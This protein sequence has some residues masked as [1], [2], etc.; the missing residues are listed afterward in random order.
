MARILIAEDDSTSLFI[1]KSLLEKWGHDVIA[2]G[3]GTEALAAMRG[4][5]PPLLAILDWMLPGMSGPEICRKLRESAGDDKPY[6]YII[7]L[8]VKGEKESIVAGLD[9]GA[10]D[11]VIKPFDYQELKLRIRVGE[12][13]LYLQEQLRK[14]ALE[15]PLTGLP[16]R[17]AAISALE[18]E[19]ARHGRTREPFA[20]AILDIDHF[21]NVNDVYGH[22]TGDSVLVEVA[23]RMK[24]AVRPYD[25]VGRFGGEEFL[26]VFP[27]LKKDDALNLSERIRAAIEKEPFNTAPAGK[28]QT[29]FRLTV[30]LGV[31]A[32]KKTFRKADELLVEADNNLYRAKEDGRNKVVG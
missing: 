29:S 16:N 21:K 5:N 7:L 25:T 26:L 6:Q 19:I 14:A 8:T 27:G 2:L 23:G 9:S 15:D 12:R 30:S 31:A 11:Y 24:A 32:W 3:D 28:I 20:A 22:A 1:L 13:I 17:R 10:D 18:A 4:E